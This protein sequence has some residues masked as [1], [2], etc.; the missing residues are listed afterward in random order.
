M[1]VKRRRGLT[2]SALTGPQAALNLLGMVLVAFVDSRHHTQPSELRSKEIDRIAQNLY[3]GF[4][5]P[6][7]TSSNKVP[8][9]LDYHESEAETEIPGQLRLHVP[10][11]NMPHTETNLCPRPDL[12]H[13]SSLHGGVVLHGHIDIPHDAMLLVKPPHDVFQGGRYRVGVVALEVE[14]R[15]NDPVAPTVPHQDVVQLQVLM[16]FHPAC[17][18]VCAVQA[19]KPRA[20]SEKYVVSIGHTGQGWGV[21]NFGIP[22]VDKYLSAMLANDVHGV[23]SQEDDEMAMTTGSRTICIDPLK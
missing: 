13:C 16:S 15:H 22:P 5:R 10:M 4:T 19:P 12:A 11:S 17:C 23:M 8:H 2:W 20:S 1:H 14:G 21:C 18:A 7:T 6:M 9:H 3:R